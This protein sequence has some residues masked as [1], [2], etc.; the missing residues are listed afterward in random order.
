MP[1]WLDDRG[2]YFEHCKN[3]VINN[4]KHNEEMKNLINFPI[5]V[6]IVCLVGIFSV[7]NVTAGTFSQNP[8]ESKL[9]MVDKAPEYPG[10]QMAMYKFLAD[11]MVYP[12]EAQ[13]ARLQGRVLLSFQVDTDGNI[14]DISAVSSPGKVLTDE[15][16]RVVKLM[17]KWIPAQNKGKNVAVNFTLP[18]SFKLPKK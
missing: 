7:Q 4:Q 13:E 17:P 16:I 6:L 18:I 14:K 15:A 3:Q 11:N 2:E 9:E 10:G 5:L 8:T 12:K 1:R